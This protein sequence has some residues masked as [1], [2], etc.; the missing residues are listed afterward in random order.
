MCQVETKTLGAPIYGLGTFLYA[1]IENGAFIIGHDG[2]N[3]PPINTAFRYNPI[4]NDGII[5]LTTGSTDFATRI[6]SDW[7]FIH[8]GKVDALLFTMQQGKMLK[9]IAIGSVIII[10]GVILIA[11]F[12]EH[13]KKA[14]K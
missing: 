3:N 13:Q 11:L 9:R 5:I 12:K 10:L 4:A 6:A 7:V 8:T 1:E 14:T 2:K